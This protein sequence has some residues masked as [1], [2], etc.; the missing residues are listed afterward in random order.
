MSSFHFLSA[1]HSLQALALVA[2]IAAS[3]LVAAAR[4]ASAMRR[5]APRATVRTV[6]EH[7]SAH[8]PAYTATLDVPQLVWPG[9]TVVRNKVNVAIVMWLEG[10]VRQFA[11]AVR[12]D[13]A[14]AKGLP[15]TLP[16]SSLHVSFQV[17]R[18]D[19]KVLSLRLAAASYVRGQAS[20]SNVAAGLT[21]NLATGA[22]YTLASLFRP[23]AAYLRALGRA[24]VA[25][26]RAFR[27]AG[28]RCYVGGSGPG[29]K[30]AASVAWWLS[31][32]SLVLAYPPGL[33]TAA[34]CGLA[35][36]TIA[37]QRLAPLLAVGG[38]LS[39]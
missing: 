25:G 36:I 31:G 21:F 16:E 28:A 13:L 3:P 4:P 9:Q 18:L 1:A 29:A 15:A 38:P 12:S 22:P 19:G 8:A 5:A 11:S 17:T 2:A 23:H 14:S 39:P 30:A 6:V 7:L 27:P 24:S 32:N 20:P 35:T 10:Q 26:L 34:Y 33:Y 37:A